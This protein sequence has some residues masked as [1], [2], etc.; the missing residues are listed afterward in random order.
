MLVFVVSCQSVML[1]VGAVV[2]LCHALSCQ[3][4]VGESIHYGDSMLYYSV[5]CNIF[6]VVLCSLCIAT[7]VEV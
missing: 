5:R 1:W 3:I 7:S 6:Y 2:A 4:L